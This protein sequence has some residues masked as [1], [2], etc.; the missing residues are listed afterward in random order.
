MGDIPHEVYN[1][2]SIHGRFQPFHLG[3]LTYALLA[4]QRCQ[5]L[6][7]GIT[8]P[9]QRHLKSNSADPARH[10]PENN[11]FTYFERARMILESLSDAGLSPLEV[12][13]VPY[14]ID[15]LDLLDSYCPRCAVFLRD[16]GEWTRTKISLLTEAGWLPELIEDDTDLNISATSVR[17]ALARDG[18]WRGL[19]PPGTAR[20]L[21]QIG[22]RQ[23]IRN[24]ASRSAQNLT[25]VIE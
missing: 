1:L 18:N 5:H 24:M 11:P 16:R 14:P 15:S 8:N 9:D 10:L 17:F 2:A 3:H 6:V 13:V 19:V 22:A 4:K 25:T 23:R 21:E 20:V 7:I 12:T